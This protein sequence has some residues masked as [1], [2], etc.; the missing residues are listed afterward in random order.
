VVTGKI[1]RLTDVQTVLSKTC[2][3]LAENARVSLD[4]LGAQFDVLERRARAFYFIGRAAADI[5]Q[6]SSEVGVLFQEIFVDS[7]QAIVLAMQAQYRTAYHLLRD[8]LELAVASI[9]FADH[10]VEFNMWKND[11]WDFQY[12][13]RTV[14]VLSDEYAKAIGSPVI[15][16]VSSYRDLYRFLSQY[17][18]GKYGYM[19]SNQEGV[20]LSFSQ[21]YASEFITTFNRLFSA[22]LTLFQ[23]RFGSCFAKATANY[24]Y[25]KTI[26]GE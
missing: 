15:P 11:E 8:S 14:E 9:Y 21:D 24:P 10:P 6:C 5:G 18:H 7:V 3:A 20:M 26:L 13:A 23:Y 25:L 12:T 22:I 19:T 4:T 2:K 1:Q 17:V 16:N